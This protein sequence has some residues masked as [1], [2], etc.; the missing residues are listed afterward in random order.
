MT[1][2]LRTTA[3]FVRRVGL[4][5]WSLLLYARS[6]AIRRPVPPAEIVPVL[7][8][9]DRYGLLG[10][11]TAIAAGRDAKGLALVDE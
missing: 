5:A 2:A 9:V 8:A 4:E 1:S 7:R 11:A 10:A 6:G 3:G